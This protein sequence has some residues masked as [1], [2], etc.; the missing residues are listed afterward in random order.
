MTLWADQAWM[1]FV[2]SRHRTYPQSYPQ[3]M[4]MNRWFIMSVVIST[5]W[6][7]AFDHT[8]GWLAD[9]AFTG[10]LCGG[11]GLDHRATFEFA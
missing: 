11:L 8:S 6:R 4:W 9:L 10:L 2:R 1:R 7:I 3:N 5:E